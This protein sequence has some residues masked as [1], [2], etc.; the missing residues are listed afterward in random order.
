MICTP[1]V[2][3]LDRLHDG[4]PRRSRCEP[5]SHGVG[6]YRP[7]TTPDTC[8]PANNNQTARVRSPMA[9]VYQKRTTE[10]AS[11]RTARG[12]SA[13]RSATLR[14]RCARQGSAVPNGHRPPHRRQRGRVRF[15]AEAVRAETRSGRS[16]G[17]V[18]SAANCMCS[19]DF[20]ADG[21]PRNRRS[22]ERRDSSAPLTLSFA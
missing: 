2:I 3:R 11:S 5:R 17:E 12:S 19:G 9:R 13:G 22:V 8:E 10:R 18:R 15:D 20:R 16:V 7:P 14:G 1:G 6:N 4:R 21:A